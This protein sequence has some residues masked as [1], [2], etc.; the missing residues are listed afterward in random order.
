MVVTKMKKKVPSIVASIVLFAAIVFLSSYY[1]IIPSTRKIKELDNSIVKLDDKTALIAEINEKYA[2]L[3]NEI[4]TKNA[5][6]E[7][8][9]KNNLIEKQ[10]LEQKEFRQNGFSKEYYTLSGEIRDIQSELAKIEMDRT[11]QKF[12]LNVQKE[13]EIRQ[14]NSMNNDTNNAKKA[15]Y[16]LFIVLGGFIIVLPLLYL[17]S[18]FNSITKLYNI[19]KARWSEVDVYLKQRA[20]LIPNIVESV[21]GYSKHEKDTLTD[22]ISARSKVANATSKEEEIS[23]NEDLSKAVKQIFALSEDYPE[24]KAD[25]N[26]MNLQNNLRVI[27]DKISRARTDYNY[28]VLRYK[29][30]I[31]VFPSNIVAGI[32]SFKPELFFEIKEEEKENPKIKFN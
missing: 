6:K 13:K 19:V 32:F 22:V 10:A 21:K 29:N 8:E 7:K 25:Q 30:K 26:F 27:E 4:E 2:N 14:V 28:A 3:E 12:D 11:T 17:W 20:D 9:L 31:G 15:G 18:S 16:I 23:A 1:I 5:N 24:L